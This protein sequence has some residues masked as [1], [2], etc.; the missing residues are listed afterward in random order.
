MLTQA[1]VLVRLQSSQQRVHQV[2][3]QAK[4]L[5]GDEGDDVKIAI[6]VRSLMKLKDLRLDDAARIVTHAVS[7]EAQ[8][9]QEVD[10]PIVHRLQIEQVVR[11]SPDLTSLGRLRQL[12][13]QREAIPAR[14]AGFRAVIGRYGLNGQIVQ[15]RAQIGGQEPIDAFDQLLLAALQGRRDQSGEPMLAWQLHTLAGHQVE[16]APEDQLRL[17]VC[18]SHGSDLS[19]QKVLGLAVETPVPMKSQD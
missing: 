13:E 9:G 19:G 16:A 10:Q 15:N 8:G 12:L 11:P 7:T 1:G 18:L 5:V 17:E 4:E 6:G 2:V 14:S 3:L